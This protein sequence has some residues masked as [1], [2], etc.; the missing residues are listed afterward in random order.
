[1]CAMYTSVSVCASLCWLYVLLVGGGGSLCMYFVSGCACMCMRVVVVAVVSVCD[2]ILM[3]ISG[4]VCGSGICG[5][6]GMLSLII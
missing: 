2:S 4:C 3:W 6:G 1:M 5:G